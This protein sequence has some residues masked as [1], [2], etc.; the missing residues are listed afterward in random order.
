V[1]AG[2]AHVVDEEQYRVLQE[3]W[4]PYQRVHGRVYATRSYGVFVDLGIVVPGLLEYIHAGEYDLES[5]PIGL[6][7]E[8]VVAGFVKGIPEVK[9]S[10]R[11]EHLERATSDVE[12]PESLRGSPPGAS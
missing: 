3:L 11:P 9:L 12:L 7:I 2:G 6:E 10:A 8:A 1:N 5:H 4:H